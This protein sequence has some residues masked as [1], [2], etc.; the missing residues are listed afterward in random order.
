MKR[1]L[2]VLAVLVT[3]T[4]LSIMLTGCEPSSHDRFREMTY[5]RDIDA[6]A[7]GFCD[8]FDTTVLLSERATRLSNWYNR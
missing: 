7:L 4:T 2:L 5:R 8:D 3:V 6:D 1:A